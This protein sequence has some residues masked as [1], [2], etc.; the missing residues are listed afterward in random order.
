MT[1]ARFQGAAKFG[2]IAPMAFGAALAGHA[3]AD[4]RTS[5]VHKMR[6]VG[7]DPIAS[8]SAEEA[9]AQGKLH[10]AANNVAQALQAYRQALSQDP[11]SIE[12]LNGVAVCYDR[13]G[14]YEDSRLH[15]EAALGIDPGSAMLLNNYGL[16]LYLQGELAEASR[17]LRLAAAAGDPQ[18]QAASLRTLA[19]IEQSQR[20]SRPVEPLIEVA[21]ASQS[22][23]HVVRTSGH[24]M[25]LVLGVPHASSAIQTAGA[26]RAPEDAAMI[27]AI[28]D[29]SPSEEARIARAEAVAIA[30]DYADAARAE[31]HALQAARE[32]AFA[33]SQPQVP[34]EMLVPAAFE[35]ASLGAPAGNVPLPMYP[36]KAPATGSSVPAPGWHRDQILAMASPASRP[37]KDGYNRA[38]VRTAM[39]AAGLV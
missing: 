19:R 34:A 28:G 31:A 36:L 11:D 1:K 16:S 6:A 8:A 32:L 26:T 22:A 7:P 29:L 35:T 4:A 18:V 30:R 2:R 9:R 25:R 13:L 38:S 33:Q 20:A 3:G 15:Y 27:A 12:S 17:F 21:Q 14:R 5:D 10:L 37:G 23:P 39:L 24:E